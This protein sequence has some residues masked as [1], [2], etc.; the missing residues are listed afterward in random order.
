[1]GDSLFLRIQMGYYKMGMQFSLP[2]RHERIFDLLAKD[3]FETPWYF[4]YIQLDSKPGFNLGDVWQ[5]KRTNLTDLTQA[6][7][8]IGDSMLMMPSIQLK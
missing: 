3:H 4:K 6:I 2:D 7:S 1:M 5:H 8:Y